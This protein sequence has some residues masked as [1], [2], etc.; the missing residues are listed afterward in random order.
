V[1]TFFEQGKGAENI[2]YTR[3]FRFANKWPHHQ[4][5][6]MRAGSYTFFSHLT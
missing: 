5:N 6:S 4:V 3:K 2:K 1:E